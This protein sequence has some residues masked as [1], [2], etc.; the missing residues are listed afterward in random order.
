MARQGQVH[1]RACVKAQ[2]P[3]PKRPES[4]PVNPEKV[5]GPVQR[6]REVGTVLQSLE[7]QAEEFGFRSKSN[8][9]SLKFSARGR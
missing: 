3:S 1:S 8:K 2:R 5:G 9:E 7:G 4:K 6:E